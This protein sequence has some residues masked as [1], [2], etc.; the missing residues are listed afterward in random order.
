MWVLIVLVVGVGVEVGEEGE[1]FGSQ[2]W[3]EIV[4]GGLVWLGWWPKKKSFG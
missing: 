4:N 2:G 3:D 1:R